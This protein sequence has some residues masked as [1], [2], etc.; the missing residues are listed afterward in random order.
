ME[1]SIINI[2]VTVGSFTIFTIALVGVLTKKNLI[3]I[4]ISLSIAES[5]LF[6]FFIGNHFSLEKQAP[7]VG[8]NLES[9]NTLTMTDPIPQ[10]MILTTI[11]IA[12]AILSLALSFISKY[13]QLSNNIDIDKM[14]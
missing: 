5:S 4:F 12:I 8:D 7:I 13:K 3:K 10:A 14:D 11:V 1:N 6:L 2:I 9:F